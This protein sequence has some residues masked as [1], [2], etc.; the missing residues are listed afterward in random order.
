MVA[1]GRAGGAGV[2]TH[3]GLACHWG[4]VVQLQQPMNPVS[5]ECDHLPCPQFD[6]RP[7][8]DDGNAGPTVKPVGR[9]RERRS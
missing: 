3:L 2:S 5:I 1:V 6:F 8:D 9:K 4:V 7:A